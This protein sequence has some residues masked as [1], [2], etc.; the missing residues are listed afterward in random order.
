[1]GSGKRASMREGP[2]AALFRRT[3]EGRDAAPPPAAEPEAPA[4]EAPE[5]PAPRIPTPQER[6][7]HAFSSDLPE[8]M[9]AP[10]APARADDYQWSSAGTDITRQPELR[11]VGVGGGGVNAVNRMIEAGVTGVEFI[12]LNT[13]AQSLQSSSAH[14]TLQLGADVTRGLGSGSDPDRGR[15]AAME[16]SDRIKALLKGSDMVF[17]TAGEGGGTGTG[18]A[19]VVARVARELGALTVGIVTK[20]FGF[21]GSR[22]MQAAEIG[23]EALGEEVDTLIV[24]PNNRLLSVLDKQ[25]SMVEAFRVA[26]DVL[27]QGV[28]GVSDLITL[29]GL[30]NLDFADVRTIMSEA[31]NALLGIGMG[32]GD[33]RAV[34][35]ATAAASS[36]LLETTLEGARS[37]L[38]SIT[39]GRDLS[40][41]EVNEA[42]RAVQEAAH[43]D[44]NIIFGA[45]LDEKLEDEVWITV[46]ATGYGERRA[47][48]EERSPFR[49]P[50]GEPRVRRTAPERRPARVSAGEV[51]VPEFIPRFYDRG[52]VAA[53]HPLTARAGA[54]ALRAGG[55]AVDAAIAAMLTSFVAEPLLTGL[56]AGG[57]ML[58][59]PR[60][61]EPVLLDFFVAAP[62]RGADLSSRSPL[63]AVDVSFGDVV[64]VFHIGAS[65]VGA[66]GN[67]A[68]A[69]AAAARFGTI[70]LA[71]LAAPAA[72]LAR[73]GVEVNA[74]QAYL[75]EILAVIYSS[76]PEARALY[77]PEGRIPRAGDVLRDPE[78]ALALERLGE[79]GAA[80]FYSGD[81]ASVVSD[82][83]L[84]LGGALTMDDLA[85]YEAE[86]REPVRVRYR[87]PRRG[88]EP[89]AERGRHAARLRARLAGTRGGRAGGGGARGG[90]GARPVRTH[91]G[92]PERARLARVPRALHGLTA[93]LHD[94]HLGARRRRLGVLGD[95]HERRGL[96]DRRARDGDAPQQHHGRGGPL[97][98]GLLQPPAGAAA[99][100][101]DGAHGR[102]GRGGRAAGAGAR[103]GGLQP[104]PLGAAAG[105]RQR[106]R[107][108]DGRRRGGLRS[109]SAL[110]G[111]YGLR[112]ARHRRRRARGGRLHGRL[113]PRSESVLRWLPGR[114]ARPGHRRLRRRWRSAAW[115]CRGCCVDVN[116]RQRQLRLGKEGEG[117]GRVGRPRGRAVKP[118]LRVNRRGR[119]HRLTR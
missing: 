51:E 48:R 88:H 97:P 39:G 52:V 16:D 21:E 101:D 116:E 103:L 82:R 86:P 118:V 44:A 72:A 10:P 40:L 33:K 104:H 62:G 93:G 43:P 34:E 58:V 81:I 12:A 25:T 85:S 1:M 78:L 110:R 30:I 70:P 61:G 91:A 27:R 4:P 22:R 73:D 114:R 29:P 76:T 26:D 37:I 98:A 5:A 17:I 56:G 2:L 113:V 66:Y 50:A 18:A 68:G 112:G 8:N 67:P 9:M 3:D 32:S 59:V 90:D 14:V 11:V 19:P 80:P 79:E 69:C 35:A 53:G 64:Q 13:D 24:V 60:S 28:Q 74:Q 6:L 41:W 109:A 20:P 45:M 38:L 92:V 31:G 84:E 47:P 42:A 106:A 49:E 102:A 7:R 95:V 15:S 119:T 23:I 63:E 55:N 96:R 87:G 100:V 57:Y 36:P 46:V 94:P 71:D 115:R 117:A 83:V 99:A 89:A 105:D 108:R 111:P 54:D 77:M 107:P 65:S 75:F